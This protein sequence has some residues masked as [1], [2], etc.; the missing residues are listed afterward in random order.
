MNTH[1][2]ADAYSY[3]EKFFKCKMTF[4]KL[5]RRTS[6]KHAISCLNCKSSLTLGKSPPVTV[7]SNALSH[8][9]F[10]STRAGDRHGQRGLLSKDTTLNTCSVLRVLKITPE[11]NVVVVF[12]FFFNL[13]TIGE[14]SL[15]SKKSRIPQLNH[16]ESKQK[17][18]HTAHLKKNKLMPLY[19]QPGKISLILA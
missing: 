1:V 3:T 4:Q 10:L 11:K 5:N 18:F 14:L 17:R 7:S 9:W 12:F 13:Q 8:R 15:R 2:Q 16:D 6:K 19:I